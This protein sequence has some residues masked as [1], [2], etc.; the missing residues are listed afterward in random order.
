MAR[1]PVFNPETQVA[2]ALRLAELDE[3][4]LTKALATAVGSVAITQLDAE[5]GGFVSNEQLGRLAALGIRGE[6][7][8]ACP[9]ILAAN[10]RLLGYYRLLFGISQKEFYLGQMSPFKPMEV[11]GRLRPQVAEDLPQ[12]CA[13]LC[14]TASLLLANLSE[15][16]RPG[17][18]DLQLLTLGQQLKGGRLNEIGKAATRMVFAR[19]RAAVA[20]TAVEDETYDRIVLKNA[21]GRIVTVAFSSDPDIAITE[22]LTIS[23][24]NKLAVEIK[25]GTDVS[26]VHNRLGEAEK[27][28][29]KARA[30]GFTEFWTII[31]TAVSPA[32]AAQESPTTNL[33]FNLERIIDPS[34]SEWIRFR[35]EL[36]S[37]LGVPSS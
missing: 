30:K 34:D 2:F 23:V 24:T 9:V 22:E 26:N 31:N 11:A 19:I 20:D 6:T 28:H 8:F 36:T 17:V 29:Q 16:S 15:I 4:Q 12:L 21:S 7:F 18:R 32:I 13:A 1:F 27:S 5:L 14:E 3:L 25:G 37:R 10:P 33:L 35:D